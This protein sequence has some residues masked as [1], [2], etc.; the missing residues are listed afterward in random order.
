MAGVPSQLLML[1]DLVATYM[2]I[3]TMTEV[4]TK[5]LSNVNPDA[6]LAGLKV[7]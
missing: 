7:T 1:G 5:V 6:P 4:L 3:G 2:L